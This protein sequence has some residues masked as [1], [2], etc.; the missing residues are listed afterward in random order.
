MRFK[1]AEEKG[2]LAFM[3]WIL[4]LLAALG[5]FMGMGIAFKEAELLITGM[6]LAGQEGKNFRV[7]DFLVIN[8]LVNVTF[9]LFTTCFC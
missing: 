2:V 5:L 4:L 3:K 7:K 1:S 8:I 9:L 6:H